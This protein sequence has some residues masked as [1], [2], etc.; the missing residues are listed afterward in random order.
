MYIYTLDWSI[1]ILTDTR[2]IWEKIWENQMYKCND[3]LGEQYT[4]RC[5]YLYNHYTCPCVSSI[6]FESA[7]SSW[8]PSAGA[9]CSNPS[10]RDAQ[11]HRCDTWPPW[12]LVSR[13]PDMTLKPFRA[14]MGQM[15]ITDDR[16]QSVYSPRYKFVIMW[17][18]TYPKPTKFTTCTNRFLANWRN[19][20][21]FSSWSALK[22]IWLHTIPTCLGMFWG[23]KIEQKLTNRNPCKPMKNP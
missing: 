22:S 4:I 16:L 14:W 19:V 10:C 8:L 21:F 1:L 18:K 15:A 7:S 2:T 6:S 11:L 23:Q 9:T 13:F 3:K 12:L 20:V 5:I 17:I